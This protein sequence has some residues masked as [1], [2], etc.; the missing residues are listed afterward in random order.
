MQKRQVAYRRVPKPPP[1]RSQPVKGAFPKATD[2]ELREL[3]P[4]LAAAKAT[5]HGVMA[6]L[7]VDARARAFKSR[8]LRAL[9]KTNHRRPFEYSPPRTS[10]VEA[11]VVT[12]DDSDDDN[13]APAHQLPSA[14]SQSEAPSPPPPSPSLSVAAAAASETRPADHCDHKHST[15]TPAG[16]TAA[17]A[18]AAA[19]TTTTSQTTTTT[20]TTTT[21]TAVPA[22]VSVLP[23]PDP[24]P[25]AE[26]LKELQAELALLN[27][28]HAA[29]KLANDA[30]EAEET[31]RY[32]A[33]LQRKRKLEDQKN[34]LLAAST[35][36]KIAQLRLLVGVEE[37]R[38]AGCKRL[39][40]EHGAVERDIAQLQQDIS[41]LL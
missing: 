15:P 18:T 1:L 33:A 30:A 12:E 38:A 8:D 2:E 25:T 11:D 35:R 3:P 16:D 32:R 37:A 20:T 40:T 7:P 22:A 34:A 21:M 5:L 13:D 14:T 31:E 9:A 36:K 41:A 17:A 39:R 29:L 4:D 19:V 23:P 10:P 27:D 6:C 28:A 26:G 24:A